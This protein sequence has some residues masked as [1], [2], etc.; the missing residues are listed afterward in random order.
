MTSN[1]PYITAAFAMYRSYDGS[2]GTFGDTSVKA[3]NTDLVNTSVYASVD[4]SSPNRLVLVVINKAST[5]KVAALTISHRTAFSRARVYQ[6]TSATPNA[7]RGTDVVL[8]QQNALRYT[9]PAMS[10][11]TLVLE[12]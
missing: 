6:L 11:S 3:S 4:A 9:M 8:S 12:P 5:P 1:V 10:V 7:T 2:G